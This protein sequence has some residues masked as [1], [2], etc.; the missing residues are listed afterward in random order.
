MVGHHFPR[1]R[2][3]SQPGPTL[4]CVQAITVTSE[5]RTRNQIR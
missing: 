4:P 3:D 5:L 2:A 1:N